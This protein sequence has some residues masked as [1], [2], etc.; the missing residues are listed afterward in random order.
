MLN[1]HELDMATLQAH[2]NQQNSQIFNLNSNDQ[3]ASWR[4]ELEQRLID[5]NSNNNAGSNQPST[6]G[7]Q[8][9]NKT[10]GNQTNGNNENITSQISSTNANNENTA[11][12]N[13]D[14][15]Q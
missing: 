12:Q 15:K 10:N 11:Q 3:V 2:L 4:R 9:A 6:N 14:K 13:E 5:D 8:A 7:S 1:N